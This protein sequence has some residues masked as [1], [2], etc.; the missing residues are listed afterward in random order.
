METIHSGPYDCIIIGG[1]V[2]GAFLL[3]EL[4]QYNMKVLLLEKEA[5]LAQHATTHNSA[6]VHPAIMVDP[7]KE[8]LKAALAEK[9]NRMYEQVKDEL[10][11]PLRR[12]GALLLGKNE[13][14][15]AQLKQK[16]ETAR[17]RG[18]QDEV[19]LL[20]YDELHKRE[21][22]LNPDI[23]AALDM[24]TTKTSSTMVVAAKITGNAIA[25]GAEIQTGKHVAH[26]QPEAGGSSFTLITSDGSRYSAGIIINA[27][28]TFADKIA[29]MVE[30]KP[31]YRIIPR[32]GEY[33]ILGKS[34][35]DFMQHTLFSLPTKKGKGVLVIPQ[36]DGTIRLGPTSTP[37]HSPDAIP[38]T[39][40]GLAQ[41][42]AD[43]AEMARN[44]PYE[45]VIGT[46]AGVR[47]SSDYGDFFL[48]NSTEYP[49]FIHVAG[50]DSPGVTAAPAIA[51]YV[52]KELV[53]PVA[54]FSKKDAFDP[55]LV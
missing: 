37:Q 43:I 15:A 20:D 33:M 11:I 22:N 40:E 7:Q 4:S 16:M 6:L 32:R 10:G 14:E 18:L 1:G 26:I 42:R 50:I 27:A 28:G 25:H 51:A 35:A 13:D 49:G 38:V 12:T 23:L 3:R 9:G 8:P 29:A 53:Q 30:E 21:A 39:K 36:P 55:S 17:Q 2:I 5:E 34:A 54:R 46:Y 19:Q 48:K 31:P 24:P 52:M 41:I 47:A 44:V 45:H